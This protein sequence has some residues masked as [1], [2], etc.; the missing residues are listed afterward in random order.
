MLSV[1]FFLVA[2]LV[3]STYAWAPR[4]ARMGQKMSMKGKKTQTEP[5]LPFA[6]LGS[7][8]RLSRTFSLTISLFLALWHLIDLAQSPLFWQTS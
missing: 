2:V 1:V 4:G 5:G 3:V 8:Y 7:P 6:E